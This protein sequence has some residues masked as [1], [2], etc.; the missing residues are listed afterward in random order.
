VFEYARDVALHPAVDQGFQVR[1]RELRRPDGGFLRVRAARA[2]RLL[3]LT[4]TLAILDEYCEAKDDSVYAALRT[5]LLPGATMF[6]ITT[7]GMG[8]ESPLGRLRA[9]ALATNDIRA[10]GPLTDA[11]SENIR[12]LEWMVPENV[13]LDDYAAAK[14]ANPLSLI[15]RKWL[16]EQRQAV[17]EIHYQPFTSTAGSVASARGCP[18]ALGRPAPTARS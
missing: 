17:H 10:R 14:R 6:T 2:S 9:R 3:G 8:A 15:T 18:P 11:R 12:L 1:Y 16:R 13:E 5:A 7:S 4:P